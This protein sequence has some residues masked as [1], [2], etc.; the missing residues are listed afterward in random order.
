[1]HFI[2]LSELKIHGNLKS[3]NCVVDSR[4]VLKVTDYSLGELRANNEDIE[5][6]YAYWKR[7]Y[8]AST[9]FRIFL[10]LS[11][12]MLEINIMIVVCNFLGKLWTAPE[13]LRA[14]YASGNPDKNSSANSVLP[15]SSSNNLVAVQK[16][17]VYSFA[18]ILHEIVMRQG[19]FY[20]GDNL[21]MDPRGK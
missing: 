13:L 14:E 18:I 2:H 9:I 6:Y 12:E 19:P 7:K 16:G 3:S 1:M 8:K 21:M 11:D 20:L 15:I 17:D 10:R 5:D 4:F